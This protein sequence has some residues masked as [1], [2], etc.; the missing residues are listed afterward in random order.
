MTSPETADIFTPNCAITVPQNADGWGF[1]SNPLF[2]HSERLDSN[3]RPLTPQISAVA[4]TPI[5]AGFIVRNRSRSFAIGSPQSVP[6]LCKGD[7]G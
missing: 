5:N 4:K 1:P 7:E 2:L 3:Q 6:K